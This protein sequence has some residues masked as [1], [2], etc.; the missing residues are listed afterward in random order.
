MS[1]MVFW[2]D[3]EVVGTVLDH[4]LAQSSEE[5]DTPTR[6]IREMRDERWDLFLRV[7]QDGSVI[8]TAVAVSSPI[9]FLHFIGHG[10][11][12]PGYRS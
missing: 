10:R 9:S 1:S 12:Y 2:L 7:L 4:I 3:R 5:D 8:I 6:R 11:L